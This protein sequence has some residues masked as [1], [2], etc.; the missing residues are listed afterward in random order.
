MCTRWDDYYSLRGPVKVCP[1][2]LRRN[3]VGFLSVA[4]DNYVRVEIL[5][6]RDVKVWAEMRATERGLAL[7]AFIRERL[8]AV[9]RTEQPP[10][11]AA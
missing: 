5:L 10:K 11:V 2:N 1:G 4:R 7:S 3:A 9:K 6:P 8:I